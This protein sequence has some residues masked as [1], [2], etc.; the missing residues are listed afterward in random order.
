MCSYIGERK[1]EM[2]AGNRLWKIKINKR[3]YTKS[4]SR[5]TS[6]IKP[7]FINKKHH[8]REREKMIYNVFSPRTRKEEEEAI[9]N[10]HFLN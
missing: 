7:L 3:N 5:A 10:L 2:R 8:E 9:M 4:Y 1:R 6:E